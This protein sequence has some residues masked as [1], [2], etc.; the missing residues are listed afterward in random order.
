MWISPA[1]GSDSTPCVNRK[2]A[3]PWRDAGPHDWR[4]SVLVA[5]SDMATA[6]CICGKLQFSGLRA[7]A[8]SSGGEALALLESGSF[9]VVLLD[10]ALGGRS[11]LEILRTLRTRDDRTL[12]F[13]L[14]VIDS[15]EDRV[16]AFECGAD[17]FLIKP[18]VWSELVARVRA[19]LRRAVRGDR[20]ERRVGDLVLDVENR[21]VRRKE[22][23]IAL[24]PREFE[25]LHY[26]V[27]HQRKVTSR[28]A[29][30]REV[31]R[32]LR[33]SQSLDNAIDVHIAH[34]RRKI[35]TGHEV[36]LIHTVRGEGFVIFEK[37]SLET[38][39]PFAEAGP[40]A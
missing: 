25:L 23:E 16:I 22:R 13:L 36:K 3:D 12:V 37:R 19:R 15:I 32:V 17:D 27:E 9:G 18:C 11:G 33:Q 29:I 35:D 2:T 26:L 31:W 39:H 24:T 20:L 30:G 10:W 38:L 28:E 7:C 6:E 1:L 40:P 4:S 34:L 14:S 8:A 21:R 5:D